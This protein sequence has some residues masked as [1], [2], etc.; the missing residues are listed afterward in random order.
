[1]DDNIAARIARLGLTIPTPR[2]PAANYVPYVREGDL[3][4]I[5]GQ[6]SVSPDLGVNGKLGESLAVEDGQRA[7]RVCAL[8]ILA[9]A[10]AALDGDLDRIRRLVRITVFVASAPSFIEQHLVANGASDLLVEVLGDR[11]R[12]TRAAIGMASLPAD[13]AVEVDAIVAV[14]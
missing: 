9:Q 2:A 11:G 5:S 14:R 1:M 8:N 7:A 10:R 13:A 6:V 12:H 4:F 3:L